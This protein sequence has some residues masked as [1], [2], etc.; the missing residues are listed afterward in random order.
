MLHNTN[1]HI[2]KWNQFKS[3]EYT[4]M[5]EGQHTL[6][7]PQNMFRGLRTITGPPKQHVPK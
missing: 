4:K 5:D 2:I 3:G 7:G 6:K 1:N